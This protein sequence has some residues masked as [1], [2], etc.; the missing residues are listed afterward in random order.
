MF[1]AASR[2]GANDNQSI[3]QSIRWPRDHF[4][5]YHFGTTHIRIIKNIRV[6]SRSVMFHAHVKGVSSLRSLTPCTSK[7]SMTKISFNNFSICEETFTIHFLVSNST[8]NHQKYGVQSMD[9][10]YLQV[11]IMQKYKARQ[12]YQH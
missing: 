6:F 12:K 5:R 8:K 4:F 2:M 9:S 1:L 10:S 3:S 11:Q 7:S